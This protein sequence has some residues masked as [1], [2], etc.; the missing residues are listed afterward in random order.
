MNDLE[1]INELKIDIKNLIEAN[2][3]NGKR[4]LE[5]EKQSYYIVEN[6]KIVSLHIYRKKLEKTIFIKILKLSH[7]KYL[8]L[9]YTKILEIPNTISVF[10]QLTSLDLS[11][12]KI[13]KIPEGLFQ[14]SKLIELNL[15]KNNIEEIPKNISKLK[16]IGLL[17]FSR[18][19]IQK[20][21]R[22]L[23]KLDSLLIFNIDNN[24]LTTESL[25]LLK[26]KRLF[27]NIP[28]SFKLE[29]KSLKFDFESDLREIVKKIVSFDFFNDVEE[30]IN[31]LLY[32]QD[33]H[34]DWW[35]IKAIRTIMHSELLNSDA[36][37]DKNIFYKIFENNRE[38]K[39]QYQKIIN[40]LIQFKLAFE[41]N[42]N[43]I[44]I[45]SKVPLKISNYQRN[46]SQY[47]F[48]FCYKYKSIK[49]SFLYQFIVQ[50]E[51]FIDKSLETAILRNAVF[52]TYKD[53]KAMIILEEKEKRILISINKHTINGREFLS[54]IRREFNKINK[55]FDFEE[56]IPIFDKKGNIIEYEDVQFT[57]NDKV[58]SATPLIITEGKTDKTIL[59]IAWKKLYDK[60]MPFEIQSSG[61]EID[62]EKREGSADSVKRTIELMSGTFDKNR[63]LIGLFDNDMEGNNNFKGLT[64]KA[65][66]KYDITFSQRKH[67]IKNIYA[68]LLPT[69]EFRKIF[70]S[71]D[72]IG[73]RMFVIEHYFTNEVLQRHQMKGKPLFGSEVFKVNNGKASFAKAIEKLDKKEFQ[74]FKKIFDV[75]QK[76]VKES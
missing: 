51:D 70:V 67:L 20:I 53:C 4:L 55:N 54:N 27:L 41:L 37:L 9:K 29:F 65:F 73:Q 68:L 7:L 60:E 61:V 43:Q 32:V 35:E 45:P 23:L 75:I 74:H 50:M 42:Q 17:N 22:S 66:E 58:I 8:T 21:P 15:E 40:Y 72:D 28:N 11:N 62:E 47:E 13:S 1:I 59:E 2:D 52:L 36:I 63:V 57:E 26:I 25:S 12:N 14:L 33:R 38:Y 16:N 69:P 10:K 56:L 30:Q 71:E 3:E 6:N 31:F 64:K 44:L 39:Q 18:N 48:H 5:Q 46:L 34:I 24:P 19:K 76:I 49:N